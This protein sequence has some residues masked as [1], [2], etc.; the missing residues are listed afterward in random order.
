MILGYNSSY[1]FR[2]NCRAIFRLILEQVECTKV[3]STC[4]KF[5]LNM[6]LQMGRNV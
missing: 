5:S 6:A 1:T 4:S 2:P 3:H